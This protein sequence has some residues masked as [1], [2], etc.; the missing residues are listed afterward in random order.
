MPYFLCAGARVAELTGYEPQDLI[1][2]TLYHHV[3]TCDVLHLRYAHHIC[4]SPK[5]LVKCRG[6]HILSKMPTALM[7]RLAQ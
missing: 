5:F 3:H 6:G 1:E 2:K 4:E 7:Q